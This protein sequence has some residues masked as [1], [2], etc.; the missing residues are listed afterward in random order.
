MSP[1]RTVKT[2]N[3]RLQ[4]PA[5]ARVVDPLASTRASPAAA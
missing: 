3:P 5:A 4:R 1:D 2:P